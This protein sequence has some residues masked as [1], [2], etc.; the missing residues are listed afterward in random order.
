MNEPAAT[1]FAVGDFSSWNAVDKSL[2]ALRMLGVGM[3]AVSLLGLRP[4]FHD[5]VEAIPR[6]MPQPRE[7]V[8]RRGP[9][10][11][12]CTPGT[13]A[14]R[15]AE[16]GTAASLSDALS[17]WLVP[18][19]ARRIQRAIADGVLLVWVRVLDA[20]DERRAC[21]GL[22]TYCLTGVEVHDLVALRFVTGNGRSGLHRRS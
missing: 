12:C 11:V 15:L 8:Y 5:D 20:D 14:D 19:E 21:T 6:Q 3:E 4:L 17:R 7:F 22:L 1:R 13:L 9:S 10:V 2:D 18:D 16:Q